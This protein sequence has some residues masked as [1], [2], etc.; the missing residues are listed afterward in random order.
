MFLIIGFAC[1]SCS[2]GVSIP[3]V[4]HIP[5]ELSPCVAN[6]QGPECVFETLELQQL[7]LTPTRAYDWMMDVLLIRG[8]NRYEITFSDENKRYILATHKGLFSL[9][10]FSDVEILITADE[11]IQIKSISRLPMGDKQSNKSRVFDLVFNFSQK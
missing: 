10:S 7:E 6:D 9:V 5:T 3:K 8:K 2:P 1:T 11:K 4:G